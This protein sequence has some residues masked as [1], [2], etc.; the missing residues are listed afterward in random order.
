MTDRWRDQAAAY[1]LDALEPDEREAFEARLAVDEELRRLVDEYREAAGEIG[2]ALEERSPPPA[3]RERIMARATEGRRPSPDEAAGRI[4]PRDA[5]SDGGNRSSRGAS[6]LAWV[7]LAAAV[8]GLIWVGLENRELGREA[9]ELRA[10]I[11]R[12]RASL[13]ETES[14]L[15]RL[16]SIAPLLAGA[17][18]RFATLTAEGAQP[19]LRLLWSPT[20]RI[21]LVAARNLPAPPEDRTFQLW[22]IRS[23]EDP[24]SLGTFR[25]EPDG[26]ALLTLSPDV[27]DGDFDLGAVTEEPAGGS[28][29]PTG[30]P[31]LAGPWRSAQE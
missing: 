29:Q 12:M 14:E 7:A 21:L 9:V 23:G 25:T 16:D 5:A 27:G 30:T 31:F 18:V 26:E 11:A 15:A 24:V 6:R 1:A 4:E 28:P 20:Q 17:D 10:E 22:G 8:A 19:G 2:R 3:L 13:A